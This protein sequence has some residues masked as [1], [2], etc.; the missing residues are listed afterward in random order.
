MAKDS[1]ISLG[2]GYYYQD[3]KDSDIDDEEGFFV[4]GDIYKLW[5]YQRWNAR[6]L[7]Q[8]GLD[9]NDFGSERLG[10]EWFAGIIANARYD[11]ARSFYGNVS[12][13]YRYGDFINA[14]RKDNRYRAGVGLGWDPTRWMNLSLEYNFNKLDSN[15]AEN[16]DENRVWFQVKLQPDKPWRW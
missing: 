10:F 16:Y 6:L 12:A 11:F 2:G 14:D 5:K 1:R 13:R 7:G 3:F 15:D 8:A 9:R 4:N